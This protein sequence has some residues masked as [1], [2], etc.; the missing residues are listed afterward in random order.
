LRRLT[1]EGCD[2]ARDQHGDPLPQGRAQEKVNPSG[3]SVLVRTRR[4]TFRQLL[5]AFAVNAELIRVL[6][7]LLER[8][9]RGLL[10]FQN[11]VILRL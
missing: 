5:A 7:Q 11:L 4:C 2:H 9:Q 8:V 1:R 6:L 10:V 3:A